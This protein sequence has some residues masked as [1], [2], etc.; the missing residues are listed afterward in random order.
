MNF[1]K[2]AL[3]LGLV[4]FGMTETR[5]QAATWNW[6]YSGTGI[7]GG[8]GTLTTNNLAPFLVTDIIGTA[9]GSTIT[10]LYP[11]GTPSYLPPYRDK[12]AIIN[13]LLFQNQPQLTYGG[14][15]FHTEALTF[16]NQAGL[17]LYY[18]STPDEVNPVIG[19]ALYKFTSGY[20]NSIGAWTDYHGVDFVATEVPEPL[21]V[22]GSVTGI[23]LFGSL[24]NLLKKKSSN[25]DN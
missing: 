17:V 1:Q 15:G 19:Y 11:P 23:A 5:A 25:K 13:D 9:E 20:G 12:P 6:S 4:I 14:I 18:N 8:S 10:G 24:A 16:A 7:I 2:I 3:L 22:L 21:N